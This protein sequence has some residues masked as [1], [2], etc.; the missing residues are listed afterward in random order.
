MKHA[1]YAGLQ[2]ICVWK[3]QETRKFLGINLPH[4]YNNPPHRQNYVSH[5]LYSMLN[6]SSPP[7]G[8]ILATVYTWLDLFL[9]FLKFIFSFKK[10]RPLFKALSF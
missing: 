3:Q 4:Y 5:F 8:K 6:F 1:E 10:L 9:N 2:I 7:I